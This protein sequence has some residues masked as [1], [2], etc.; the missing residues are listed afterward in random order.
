VRQN[1]R[2]DLNSARR[3]GSHNADQSR[4]LLTIISEVSV[5]TRTGEGAA[6]EAS[7]GRQWPF[8]TVASYR[9]DQRGSSR[10]DGGGSHDFQSDNAIILR[11]DC[12]RNE[13]SDADAPRSCEIAR[14]H[15]RAR[16]RGFHCDR[17]I[18]ARA[19]SQADAS[20]S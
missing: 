8:I 11:K 1:A 16:L 2:D 17:S 5:R 18:R 3:C 10:R 19:K 20:E 6:H 9:S 14:A 4:T 13:T 15:A 12:P 7:R